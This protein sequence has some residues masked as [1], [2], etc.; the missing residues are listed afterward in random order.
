M[1]LKDNAYDSTCFCKL[2]ICDQDVRFGVNQSLTFNISCNT[3]PQLASSAPPVINLRFKRCQHNFTSSAS[4]ASTSFQALQSVILWPKELVLCLRH[5]QAEKNFCLSN[6]YLAKNK[7]LK[8]IDQRFH[9]NVIMFDVPESYQKYIAHLLQATIRQSI[10]LFCWR[11]CTIL[12]DE[13]MRMIPVY[14]F[15]C[16]P[17]RFT[18]KRTSRQDP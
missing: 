10:L 11:A 15:S 3:L 6:A 1:W 16:R 7:M 14:Y 2:F 12:P 18:H 8:T 4:T 5:R 17:F 9:M 13:L